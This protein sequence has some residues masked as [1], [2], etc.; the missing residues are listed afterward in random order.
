MCLIS[1]LIDSI[2]KE[3]LELSPYTSE[4]RKNIEQITQFLGEVHTTLELVIESIENP[5]LNWRPT[6]NSNTIGNLLKHIMGAEAFW[7]HHVVSSMET[8]RVRASEFEIREFQIID[9]HEEFN[10]VKEVTNKVLEELTDD[11]LYELRQFWSRRVEKKMQ[12]T[13]FWCLMHIIEHTALHIGQIFY[14]RKMYVV[15][16]IKR[17]YAV[18]S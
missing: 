13:I 1:S 16:E 7:I 6:H 2:L 14:I 5:E 10:H 4:L 12:A 3:G 8:K 18:S 11:Q 17:E 15:K 9:L